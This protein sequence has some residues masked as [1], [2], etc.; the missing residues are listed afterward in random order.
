MAAAQ[1]ALC[2]LEGRAPCG[3]L[4]EL[5]GEVVD[6]RSRADAQDAKIASDQHEI[7]QILRAFGEVR[8]ALRDSIRHSRESRDASQAA[9]KD[10][11]IA[12]EAAERT[13]TLAYAPVNETLAKRVADSDRPLMDALDYGS[14]AGE[15]TKT[16]PVPVI[17]KRAKDA[18]REAARLAVEAERER[19]AAKLEADRLARE[20]AAEKE[21]IALAAKLE[22]ARTRLMHS[23]IGAAVAITTAIA[24]ATTAYFTMK[25]H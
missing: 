6:L 16:Q 3:E 18:E 24:G 7:G 4:L 19:V 2:E 17:V 9:Q 8:D 23:L 10:A 12:R 5:R 14:D 13:A 22:L 25:G 15:H 20:A 1:P 21:R 11:R